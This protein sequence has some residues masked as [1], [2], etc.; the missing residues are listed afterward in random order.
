M[1]ELLGTS[2]RLL[3]ALL[4]FPINEMYCVCCSCYGGV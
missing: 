4:A 3:F 1:A 2:F